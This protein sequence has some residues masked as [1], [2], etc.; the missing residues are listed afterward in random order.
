VTRAAARDA[1]ARAARSASSSSA[2]SSSSREPAA[3]G[4]FSPG[5]TRG[6]A[7]ALVGRTECNAGCILVAG[8]TIGGPPSSSSNCT[9]RA[10]RRA[11]CCGG[12]SSS[13]SSRL[14]NLSLAALI[15][16]SVVLTE[17]LSFT[18]TIH[19]HKCVLVGW[20]W[21]TAN[22]HPR[23][24]PSAESPLP[25]HGPQ[26]PLAQQAHSSLKGRRRRRRE[27]RLPPSP[28]PSPGG[29]PPPCVTARARARRW[30][31]SWTSRVG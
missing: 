15:A 30:R 27:A 16:I 29:A 14:R 9:A 12:S 10:V 5:A 28:C 11:R 7:L 6:G 17:P 26:A 4:W 19:Q 22:R 13:S 3:G 31:R 21:M 2:A 1:R 8:S 25:T 23:R 20:S 24:M 18:K